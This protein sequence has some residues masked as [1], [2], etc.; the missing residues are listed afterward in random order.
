MLLAALAAHS[1]AVAIGVSTDPALTREYDGLIH[2]RDLFGILSISSFFLGAFSLMILTERSINPLTAEAE[3]I[4]QARLAS[5]TLTGL[6]LFGNAVYIPKS[7]AL[8]AEKMFVPASR[9]RLRLP[10]S[11][12][13]DLIMSPG[14]DG[15]TPGAML[16]PLG[17]DLLAVCEGEAKRSFD[18]I[19][20]VALENQM[21][22]LK[23]GFGLMK[24]YHIKESEGHIIVR[25]EYSGLRSACRTVR[26]DL[27]DTCRQVSCFGCSCILTG[28]ARALGQPVRV[29]SV[30][31]AQER[32][33]F[34]LEIVPPS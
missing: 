7:G 14:S 28:I 10:A 9:S 8:T 13:D 11:I 18:G 21:Q 19:G 2:L 17:L 26:A 20:L 6:N 23:F 16:A 4:S 33:T 5:Q 12:T 34:R 15:S 24:D 1:D 29:E 27:P 22:A 25:V 30:D 3:M 31:N 32:V